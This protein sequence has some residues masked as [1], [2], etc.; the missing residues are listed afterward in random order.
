MDEL[1]GKITSIAE[2]AGAK[3]VTSGRYPSWRPDTN[4]SLL[5]RA[6]TIYKQLN[7]REPEVKVVH[8]GIEPAV[9]GEKFPGIEMISL[10]ASIENPHS[11]QE[12]LNI[13]SVDAA[14]E[15]LLELIPA[16]K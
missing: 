7:H 1:T 6:K 10:G 3:A 8:A 14:W 15:F 2:S 5:R 9:I 4:S 12:R 16:L 13:A 11:P